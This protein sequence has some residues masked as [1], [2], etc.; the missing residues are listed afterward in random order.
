MAHGPWLGT[1]A[2][3]LVWAAGAY[4]LFLVFIY[5]VQP[6]LLYLPDLP[7]RQLQATPAAAGLDYEPLTLVTADGVELDAWFLPA[8]NPRATLL[9][10]HGNAGNISHRLDSLAVFNRLGL[11]TL[12]FDYRGYGRSQGRPSEAGTYRDATAAWRYLTEARALEAGR[13]VVFGRSLGGAIAAELAARV[14]PAALI[15]ESAFTSAPDLGAQLYP[16][17]PVRWISRFRYPTREY[18]AGVRCPVL[19]V[20]SRD[21]EIT[22]FGHAERLFAAVPGPRRLLELRGGHN[23]GFLRSYDAY[24]DG[25]ERF[26]GESI[27][28]RQPGGATSLPGGNRP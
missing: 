10:L 24:L 20:H 3:A 14:R 13:I 5:L 15:L 9:F 2:T 8:P 16:F 22:D 18:L 17:L 19:I 4:A 1:L 21:D 11:S 26:L 27:G 12:I 25:L 7:S 23:D 28:T 6:R